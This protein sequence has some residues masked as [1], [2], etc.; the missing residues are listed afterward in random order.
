MDRFREMEAFV[1]VVEEGSF[2][3]AGEALRVS[4]A[5]VSRAV[6]DLERRLGAR[7]L[8]RTTRR[9]SITEAGRAYYDRCK[10]IIAELE[11]ADSAVGAV[12]GRAVGKLRVNAPVSF[13]IRHLSA[14]W[15]EFMREYPQVDLEIELSDRLVDVVDEGFDA[16]IRISRLVDST[17]VHRKLATTRIV[18]AASPGYL[19]AHGT[20]THPRELSA[21]ATIGYDYAA[22]GDT[23]RFAGH[24]GT[25]EITTHP[26]ARANN[27]DTCRALALAGQ[28]IA[29]QPDFLIWEDLASGRLVPVLGDYEGR[30]IGIYVVYPS[31]KHL[32]VKV[33]ALVDFLADRF[34]EP[35]WRRSAGAER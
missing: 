21:H 11:E 27:G 29:L 23:W 9:L 1:A 15:G 8:Q 4:K 33:R 31:R 24:D 20:P 14:L 7:L 19:T 22:H 32:S 2:V 13:G 12:T 5:A 17:L 30:E 35:P 10:Q 28:G 16:V 6:L 25:H 18:A 34:A 3:A 26:R